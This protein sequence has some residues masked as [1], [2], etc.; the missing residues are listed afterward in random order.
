MEPKFQ[1]S[2]IPKGPLATAGTATKV[3]RQSDRSILGTLAVFVFVLSILLAGGVFAYEIYLGTDIDK[4]GADLKAARDSLEPEIIN[5]ISDLDERIVS[6]KNILESH[7][8][9]SPL[10]TYLEEWTVS[11]VRF[12]R[13][14]YTTTAEGLI[15]EMSGEARGYSSVAQQ[16]Q[17]FGA[18]DS[19]MKSP[20]FADLNLDEEGKVT[21]SFEASVDPALVSF[22]N[23]IGVDEMVMPIVETVTTPVENTGVGGGVDTQADAQVEAV[24]TTGTATGTEVTTD[25]AVG[26]ETMPEATSTSQTPI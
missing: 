14:A 10:F 18:E 1:S 23:E 12:T 4:M 21:F 5:R 13:F 9:I 16:A 8:I 2:F 11:N 15:I 6:T 25:E 20:I 24:E 7:T 17:I 22:K 26:V 19:P 3:S